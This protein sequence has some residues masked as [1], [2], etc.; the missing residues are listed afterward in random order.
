MSVKEGK[1]L[2]QIREEYAGREH[3]RP[4]KLKVRKSKEPTKAEL[5]RAHEAELRASGWILPDE[6]LSAD[7][8][9]IMKKDA[10]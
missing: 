4:K 3:E 6:R 1:S 8:K 7:E 5:H 10:E 9:K 2:A